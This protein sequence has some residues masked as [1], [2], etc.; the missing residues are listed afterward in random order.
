M[1]VLSDLFVDKTIAANEAK[2][3]TDRNQLLGERSGVLDAIEALYGSPAAGKA[4]MQADRHY[5]DQGSGRPMTGGLF[6][7]WQAEK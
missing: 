2:T 1:S 5:L 3:E 7:D 4:V 6:L